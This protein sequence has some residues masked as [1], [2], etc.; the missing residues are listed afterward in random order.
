MTQ[1]FCFLQFQAGRSS[2]DEPILRTIAL[3][4][5]VFWGQAVHGADLRMR[6]VWDGDAPEV[7][8][9]ENRFNQDCRDVDLDAHRQFVDAETRGVRDAVVYVAPLRRDR[10]RW[11]QPQ[12]N[13]TVRIEVSDCRIHPHIVI[14]QA[15]DKLTIDQRDDLAAHNLNLSFL[16]NPAIGRMFP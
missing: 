7:Q 16:A 4:I 13:E 8:Q 6:I 3:A 14:A 12:R 2:I 5:F 9:I 1:L 10:D 11:R 15:G